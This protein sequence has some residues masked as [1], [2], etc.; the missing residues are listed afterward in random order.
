[1]AKYPIHPPIVYL[2]FLH[3]HII[4][5]GALCLMFLQ[6]KIGGGYDGVFYRIMGW[7]VRY[8]FRG[9]RFLLCSAL[10][11]CWSSSFGASSFSLFSQVNSRLDIINTRCN[12]FNMD[13]FV[14]MLN[15]MHLVKRMATC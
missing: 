10:A 14:M 5:R 15:K 6:Y 8:R 9:A 7:F 3:L 13:I 4:L 2:P 12:C 11:R 1:M